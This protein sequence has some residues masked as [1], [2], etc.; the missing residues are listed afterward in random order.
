MQSLPV[1]SR[2]RQLAYL[3]ALRALCTERRA[4]L[5]RCRERLVRSRDIDL[6]EI[7]HL[8]WELQRVDA[9]VAHLDGVAAALGVG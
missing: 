3:A 9:A 8:R 6:D 2:Q 5:E 1:L 4:L 7:A